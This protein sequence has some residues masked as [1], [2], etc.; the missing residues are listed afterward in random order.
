MVERC[1]LLVIFLCPGS[2]S[3][4]FSKRFGTMKI[5]LER[6][7][8]S[9]PERLSCV[10]CHEQFWVPTIR[11]LLYNQQ[12]I[13]QGDVC[14]VCRE[15]NSSSF[16]KKLRNQANRLIQESVLCPRKSEALRCRAVEILE[17]SEEPLSRPT[18]FHWLFK[19]LEIM[20]EETQELEAARLRASECRY[21]LPKSTDARLK[22]LKS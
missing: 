19:R 13:I 12:N 8:S 4:K 20:S 16:Q 10:V 9:C 2:R 21:A 22:H 1:S 7:L 6:K 15:L 5:Q 18:V 11:S 3:L 17:T 14:S